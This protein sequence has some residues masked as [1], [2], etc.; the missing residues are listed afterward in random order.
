M[1]KDLYQVLDTLVESLY[2]RVRRR[3]CV[4]VYAYVYVR[5]RIHIYARTVSEV[6]IDIVS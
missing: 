3:V 6:Y 5:V 1:N 2:I 4:Y